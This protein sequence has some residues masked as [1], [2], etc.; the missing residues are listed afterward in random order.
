MESYNAALDSFRNDLYQGRIDEDE[1]HRNID[2]YTARV[3]PEI[4]RE[5]TLSIIKLFEN[6]PK[7]R[8]VYFKVPLRDWIRYDGVTTDETAIRH[9]HQTFP[10]L[11]SLVQNADDLINVRLKIHNIARRHRFEF[12]KR[13]RAMDDFEYGSHDAILQ[14][15]NE[16]ANQTTT[17]GADNES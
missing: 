8:T 9:L 10:Q 7:F 14:T 6:D 2:E 5:M 13:L 17:L 1:Y 11:T 12:H 15:L 16:S 3:L 4:K